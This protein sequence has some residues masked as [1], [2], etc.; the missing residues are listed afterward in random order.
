VPPVSE[1]INGV[2]LRRLGH[3]VDHAPRGAA[4]EQGRRRPLQDLNRFIVKGIPCVDTGIAQAIEKII[5]AHRKTAQVDK[6]AMRAAFAGVQRDARHVFERVL[7]IV[8][9]LFLDNLLGNHVD[10]LRRVEYLV[11]Q[12]A[13]RRALVGDG[14]CLRRLVIGG[15]GLA[16]SAGNR[17]RRAQAGGGYADGGTGKQLAPLCP[18]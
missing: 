8:D 16:E 13:D 14:D 4:A 11:R 17:G 10:G 3:L 6:I 18:A 12:Q 1:V 2:E 5:I 9:A 15:D 7:Q